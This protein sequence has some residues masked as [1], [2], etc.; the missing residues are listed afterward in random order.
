MNVTVEKL[1]KS[2]V[3]L[4][5]ELAADEVRP[6]VETAAKELSKEHPVKGFR[7]GAAPLEVMRS[8]VGDEKIAEATVKALVPRTYVAA[9]LEHDDIEAIGAPEVDVERFAIGDSCAYRATVAVLPAVQ[10][11]EYRRVRVERRTVA[12]EEGEVARE[13]ERLRNLR[14]TYLAVPRGATRGD[15]VEVDVAATMDRVPLE[16]GTERQTLLLG[17]GY[18][19]P[20]FEEHL[21]GMKEGQTKTFSLTFPGGHHRTDLRGRGVDFTV[22]VRGVQQ[23]ILPELTDHFAQGLGQFSGLHDLKEKFTAHLRE[24]KEAEERERTHR[25]LLDAVVSQA[26]FGEFPE[27]LVERELDT[28]LAELKEGAAA[29]G[30]PFPEYLAQVKKGEAE[31]RENLRAQALGR[32]RSGLALRAIARAEGIAVSEEEV[33]AELNEAV[34]QFSGPKDAERKVD[35]EALRDVAAGVVRNRKVFQLLEQFQGGPL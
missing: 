22:T 18:L 21:L 7:L 9:L 17:E 4:R 25:S 26:A 29:M 34:K 32:I 13:L 15:R 24:E 3:R 33:A 16:G 14:A 1:P 10:L 23:R 12:V 19:V 8:T 31:L 11:G 28:M 30:L 5:V 20:G 27:A 6:F 35:L 2:Q